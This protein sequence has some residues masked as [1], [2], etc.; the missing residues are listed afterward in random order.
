[1]K[2]ETGIERVQALADISRSALCGSS[3]TLAP[4]LPS[5]AQVEGTPVPFFQVTSGSVQ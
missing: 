2:K 4:N 1:M 5:N 3:E